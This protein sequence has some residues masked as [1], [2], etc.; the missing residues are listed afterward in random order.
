M[1]GIIEIGYRKQDYRHSLDNWAVTA[2]GSL[3]AQYLARNI[4]H[5]ERDQRSVTIESLREDQAELVMRNFSQEMGG[6]FYEARLEQEGDMARLRGLCHAWDKSACAR[7]EITWPAVYDERW[8]K[9]T[10][11]NIRWNP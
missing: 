6:A 11:L 4:L 8:A 3:K 5:L 2:D 9:M 7:V 1:Q 10:F